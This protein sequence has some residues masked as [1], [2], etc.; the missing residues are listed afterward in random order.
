MHG[1]NH[2]EVLGTDLVSYGET[3]LLGQTAML[4]REEELRHALAEE[5]HALADLVGLRDDKGCL[6]ESVVDNNGL[7]CEPKGRVVVVFE[8][9]RGVL[10]HTLTEGLE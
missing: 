5:G 1:H 7:H 2:S 6:S 4:V 9:N 3:R 10:E 8:S